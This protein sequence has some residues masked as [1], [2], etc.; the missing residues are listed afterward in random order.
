MTI[1]ELDE[2]VRRAE[3]GEDALSLL[4]RTDG[5]WAVA[6]HV[7]GV[8]RVCGYIGEHAANRDFELFLL[9]PSPRGE[10]VEVEVDAAAA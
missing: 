8:T 1:D 7:A 3:R 4:V 6:R 9:S 5:S 10:W 2:V